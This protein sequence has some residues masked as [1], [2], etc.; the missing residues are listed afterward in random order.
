MVPYCGGGRDNVILSREEKEALWAKYCT[1]AQFLRN[2]IA[3]V[4]YKIHTILTD[5]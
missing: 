2:L 4:P 1:A 5:N 3:A